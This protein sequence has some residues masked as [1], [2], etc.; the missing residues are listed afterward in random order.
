MVSRDCRNMENMYGGE[1][2]FSEYRY[3][4]DIQESIQPTRRRSI[5]TEFIT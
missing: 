1:C 2:F 5:E 3:T 4:D